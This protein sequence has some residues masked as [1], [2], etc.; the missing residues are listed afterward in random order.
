MDGVAFSGK[1]SGYDGRY[2]YYVN[3]CLKVRNIAILYVQTMCESYVLGFFFYAIILA[4]EV[5]KMFS[6]YVL[7]KIYSD[8]GLDSVPIDYKSKVITIVQ[9]AIEEIKE[10]NPYAK[11]SELFD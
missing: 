5:I 1:I 9:N 3:H 6:D 8:S 2:D 11:L 4:K 7:E 10:E